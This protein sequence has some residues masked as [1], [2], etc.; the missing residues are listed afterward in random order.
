MEVEGIQTH[1]YVVLP[2]LPALA[3]L[4]KCLLKAEQCLFVLVLLHVA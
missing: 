3:F 1:D 4:L 2:D